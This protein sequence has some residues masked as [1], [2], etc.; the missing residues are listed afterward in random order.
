MADL[1]YHVNGAF[2]CSSA[3]EFQQQAQSTIAPVE[4]RNEVS[5]VKLLDGHSPECYTISVRHE[6]HALRDPVTWGSELRG[7][8]MPAVQPC[9]ELRPLCHEH[10]VNMRRTEIALM[11]EGEPTPTPAY[12]CPVTDCPVR[13]GTSHGYYIAKE[14]VLMERDMTPRHTCPHHQQFMYLAETNLEERSF[15]LW[16]CPRC[17]AT[18]TNGERLVGGE[19]K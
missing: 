16:R 2:D 3:R 18:R 19:L 9:K 1:G 17:D 8:H 5:S 12:A 14:C 7:G 13:Y 15:R 6:A 4:S 10:H 11:I